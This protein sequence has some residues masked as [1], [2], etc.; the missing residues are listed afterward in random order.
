M[1]NKI[2][3]FLAEKKPETPCLVVDLDVVSDNYTTLH[4]LLPWAAARRQQASPAQRSSRRHGPEAGSLG[5]SSWST[6][7][8][9]PF[10]TAFFTSCP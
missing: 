4:R 6:G 2:A 1:N 3:R 10:R 7:K 8:A 9:V 5:R